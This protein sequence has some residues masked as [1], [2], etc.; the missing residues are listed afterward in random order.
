MKKQKKKTR[1]PRK[2]KKESGVYT[3]S[4]VDIGK[5]TITS[6]PTPTIGQLVGLNE[7]IRTT[8]V[9]RCVS[10]PINW[11]Q[12]FKKDFFPIWALEQWPV[13]NEEVHYWEEVVDSVAYIKTP[14]GETAIPQ[15]FTYMGNHGEYGC[16]I[17]ENMKISQ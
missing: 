6:D 12:H 14:S 17:P 5:I 2:S 15:A 10:Y 1:N 8:K 11:W 4:S 16:K 3:M 13:L 9:A 7:P